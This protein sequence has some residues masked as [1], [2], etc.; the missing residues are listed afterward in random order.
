MRNIYN[1]IFYID[2]E[3]FQTCWSVPKSS[4]TTYQQGTTNGITSEMIAPCW[5]ISVRKAY[6]FFILDT[7]PLSEGTCKLAW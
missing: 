2:K 1:Y 7:V 3:I 5:P 4:V 6:F